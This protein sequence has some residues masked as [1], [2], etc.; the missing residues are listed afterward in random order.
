MASSLSGLQIPDLT[1]TIGDINCCNRNNCCNKGAAI[2]TGGD[3]TLREDPDEGVKP[4]SSTGIEKKA[5]LLN[6]N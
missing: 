2:T 1:V 4:A 5:C 3:H 6:M